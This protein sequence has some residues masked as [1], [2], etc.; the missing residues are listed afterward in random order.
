MSKILVV[1]FCGEDARYF[2]EGVKNYGSAKI[3]VEMLN[4]FGGGVKNVDRTKY[5]KVGVK[6]YSA[7][8][9]GSAKKN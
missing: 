7:K 3:M 6:N 5:F 9:Y 1:P 2:G 8:N 4:I